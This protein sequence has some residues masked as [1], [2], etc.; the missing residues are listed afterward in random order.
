MG[1]SV[2]GQNSVDWPAGICPVAGGGFVAPDLAD[3]D[4]TGRSPP[5]VKS[6]AN[7]L[8]RQELSRARSHATPDLEAGEVLLPRKFRL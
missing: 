7:R 1:T 5:N 6:I 4:E 3:P 2:L 8:Q